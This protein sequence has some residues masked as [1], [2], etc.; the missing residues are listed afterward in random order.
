MGEERSKD[1]ERLLTQALVTFSDACTL[2]VLTPECPF[3]RHENGFA[4]CSNEC[5]DLINRREVEQPRP[6]GDARIGGLS[7]TGR[8]LPLSAAGPTSAYDAAELFL[9]QRTLPVAQQGTGSLLLGLGAALNELPRPDETASRFM[10]VNELWSELERRG[11]PVESVVRAGIIPQ[12]AT[13]IGLGAVMPFIRDD[14]M[15]DELVSRDE[16]ARLDEQW[17]GWSSVLEAS[18]QRDGGHAGVQSSIAEWFDAQEVVRSV[19]Q[20]FRLA[21]ITPQDLNPPNAAFASVEPADMRAPYA[22][23]SRFTRKVAQWLN[24]LLTDSLAAVVEWQAPPPAVFMALPAHPYLDEVGLWIWERFTLT[25]LADW[26]TSSLL[27][28]WNGPSEA[29]RVEQRFW[30]ERV[31]DQAEVA[32]RALGRLANSEPRRPAP[33]LAAAD[34]ATVAARHLSAGEVHEAVHIYEGLVKL[35]PTD[36]DLLN[37]LG[38]CQ[39]PLDPVEALISLQRASLF[40]LQAPII[41]AANRVLALMLVGRAEDALRLARESE[42]IARTGQDEGTCFCWSIE[43]SPERLQLQSRSTPHEYLVEQIAYLE[44]VVGRA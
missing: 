32:K 24:R 40:P 11:V 21:G 31:F 33:K 12:V 20:V 17:A 28:E 23:S 6:I 26:S 39:L 35:R 34:F 4:T 3:Y 2:P 27:R 42:R 38:F 14:D 1:E 5:V 43:D 36:G 10:L 9:Q 8:K 22:L 30:Q 29:S 15:F 13:Q 19:T 7:L 37:N 18:F 44:G 16:L 41:N 25:D